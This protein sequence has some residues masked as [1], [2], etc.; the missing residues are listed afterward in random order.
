MTLTNEPHT[1]RILVGVGL[2]PVSL[3]IV[4]AQL[5]KRARFVDD[6]AVA[7][8]WVNDRPEGATVVAY[9][10]GVFGP[11]VTGQFPGIAQADRGVLVVD[12]FPDESVLDGAVPAAPDFRDDPRTLLR[13][14]ATV[15]GVDLA[16]A[17]SP[18]G[19]RER[20]ADVALAVLE[21]AVKYAPPGLDREQFRKSSAAYAA[22]Y[23]A[24][25]WGQFPEGEG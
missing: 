8:R 21:W 24:L 1:N 4:H 2:D 18:E 13:Q 6:P 3:R 12:R 11:A 7:L 5:G 14:A 15:L 17:L 16:L 19:G 20:D 9:G 22:E 25:M 23:A 10:V